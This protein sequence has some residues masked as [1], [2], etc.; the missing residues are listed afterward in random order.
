[1]AG[2]RGHARY[3]EAAPATLHLGPAF[4]GGTRPR[5]NE[6]LLL[7]ATALLL[8]LACSQAALLVTLARIAAFLF[9]TLARCSAT[10]LLEPLSSASLLLFNFACSATTLLFSFTRN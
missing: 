1:M 3:F 4:C 5:G 2:S 10:L 9:F 8:K 7:L 6:A